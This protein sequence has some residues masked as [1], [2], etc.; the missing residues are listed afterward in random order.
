[1]VVAGLLIATSGAVAGSRA[2]SSAADKNAA[3]VSAG[4]DMFAQKCQQC[5]AFIEGQYSFGPNLFHE[6]K[7][8]HP[9]KTPAE[10]RLLL[11]EGKGKM[12]SFDGKL[13]ADEVDDLIA[14][15]HTL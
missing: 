15:I 4:G 3:R 7:P 6:M 10:I 12:P 5:H 9:K 2:Q 8:P 1:M 14:Y 11:K 13:T